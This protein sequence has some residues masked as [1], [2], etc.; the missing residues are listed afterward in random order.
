MRIALCMQRQQSGSQASSSAPALP[1]KKSKNKFKATPQKDAGEAAPLAAGSGEPEASAGAGS[2]SA[3]Q[4]M[5]KASQ[6]PGGTAIQQIAKGQKT[7]AK[8]K[9]VLNNKKRLKKL[10]R[11]VR[12]SE[13]AHHCASPSRRAHQI[14]YVQSCQPRQGWSP[15]AFTSSVWYMASVISYPLVSF[16]LHTTV[17]APGRSKL[18]GGASG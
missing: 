17:G 12:H 16:K 11:Q 7:K 6:T 1:G 10:K 5:S 15:G 18:A 3:S 8:R 4:S 14:P 9:E 13:R 2:K